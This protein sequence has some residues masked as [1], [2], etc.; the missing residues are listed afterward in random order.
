MPDAHGER[1]AQVRIRSSG[2]EARPYDYALEPDGAQARCRL[3]IRL[4]A[5]IRHA[6]RNAANEPESAEK[7]TRLRRMLRFRRA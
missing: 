5:F 1:P 6:L 7:L 2:R 4:A 3:L